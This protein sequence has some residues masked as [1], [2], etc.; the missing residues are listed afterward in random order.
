MINNYFFLQFA[1][2]KFII[3]NSKFSP[4]RWRKL[5]ACA[6]FKIQNSLT[7]PIS[8]T[9]PTRPKN[10]PV[11]LALPPIQNSEFKI[12]NS[13]KKLWQSSKPCQSFFYE[14]LIISSNTTSPLLYVSH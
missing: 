7:R 1:N 10:L 2:S 13:Q 8:P 14:T 11:R 6:Q 12:H 9:R 4:P 5:A 3:H